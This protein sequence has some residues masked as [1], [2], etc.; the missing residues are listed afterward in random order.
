MSAPASCPKPDLAQQVGQRADTLQ[1]VRTQPAR[2]AI[3]SH[4]TLSARRHDTARGGAG[5]RRRGGGEGREAGMVQA[6]Y[7]DNISSRVIEVLLHVGCVLIADET[8]LYFTTAT[9]AR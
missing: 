5:S 8:R 6:R 2:P 3:P 4:Q 9:A 7:G 1:P